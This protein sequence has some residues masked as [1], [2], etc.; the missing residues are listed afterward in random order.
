MQL[1]KTFELLPYLHVLQYTRYKRAYPP[2]SGQR[3][4]ILLAAPM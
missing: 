1:V 3:V 2:Q 4:L